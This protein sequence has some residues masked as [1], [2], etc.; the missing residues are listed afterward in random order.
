MTIPEAVTVGPGVCTVVLNVIV[1]TMV[2]GTRTV[3]VTVVTAPET[4]VV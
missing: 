4:V 1:D 3:V 2:V